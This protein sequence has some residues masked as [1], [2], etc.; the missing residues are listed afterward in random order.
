MRVKLSNGIRLIIMTVAIV[1]LCLSVWIGG[2]LIVIADDAPLASSLTRVLIIAAVSVIFLGWL[3][4]LFW[5]R[6]RAEKALEAALKPVGPTGDEQELSERMAEAIATL[7]K[8]SPSRNFLYELPWYVIIGPPGTGKTTA[9]M[10]SGLK[11]PLAAEG[12]KAA[13]G[14]AGG[15]RYC[16]WWFA[17]DA[18]LVDTAGRYTTQDSDAEADHKSWLSFLSLLKENRPKQPINGV[19]IAF[20]LEDMM[21]MK[22][23]E[24]S[25]HAAAIRKRLLELHETLRVDFPVYALFTK[26]DLVAGFNEFFGAFPEDRRRQVWGAT[27]QTEDR[28]KNC[29]G[30]V[31]KEFDALVKRLT[32]ETADRLQAE[33]DPM[34][35]IAIFGFAAQMAGLRDQ[36]AQFLA[37][38]FEPTR[39]HAN[40]HLRGFYFS[41]G[42]QMGTPI[43]QTLGLMERSLGRET[44]S[45]MSGKGKSYFL[46]D[47]LAKV[48]FREAGWV[49]R[50]MNAVRRLAAVRYGSIAALVVLTLGISSAWVWSYMNNRRLIASTNS[51]IMEYRT[52]GKPAIE[53]VVVTDSDFHNIVDLLHKLRNM[54]AG[55]AHRN[56]PTPLSERFGLSQRARLTS[57]GEEAYRAALERTFRSRLILRLERQIEANI[58]DPMVLYEA[59]KVYLM[60][61]G[62]APKEDNDLILAWMREDWAENLYPGAANKAG[63]EELEQHLRAMLDLEGA[64]NPSVELNGALVASAQQTLARMN[65]ADRAYTLIKSASTSAPL[66]PW[67]FADHGGQDSKVVFETVDGTPLEGVQVS[68]LFTYLGFQDFFLEQLSVV[69]D[70]LLAEQWVLGEYG[71]QAA[72]EEQ[73]SQLGP[74]LLE[75]YQRDF[76]QNWEAMLSQVRLKRLSA[77]KPQ[78]LA[79]A[80][81][82]APTSP[83]RA[84]FSSIRDETMLTEERG[85]D[86]QKDSNSKAGGVVAEVTQEATKRIQNRASGWSR[87]GIDA[88]LKKSQSRLGAG[89][90]PTVPGANIEAYFRSYQQL[91]DGEPGKRPIDA[92]I[93]NLYEIYQT[94]YVAANDASQTERATANLPVQI[95]NLRGNAS[96]LPPPL[97]KMMENAVADFEGDAADSSLSQLNQELSSGVTRACQDVTANRF[98]FASD[99]ERDVPLADFSK[100]FSPNGIIDHFFNEKLAKLVDMSGGTWDWKQDSRLGRELSKAT[101]REFQRASQ[102]KDAFFSSGAPMAGTQMTVRANT[103]SADADFALLEV[104]GN[105]VQAQ[106]V[107]NAPVPLT[108]PDNSPGSASITIHPDI[109]GRVSTMAARGPWAFMRLLAKGAVS[110][111]GD[112]VSVRFLVGGREVSFKIS[113]NSLANPLTLPALHEFKCPTGF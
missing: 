66:E 1:C 35:R 70:K 59:L 61:G 38:I 29:V 13:V 31:P 10:N 79:L 94:L 76:I 82:S 60:L 101:L 105:V 37:M 58:N 34:A 41:S 63:R 112:G 109:P 108:W 17:E 46:H 71:K 85:G 21:L 2:P 55:Y 50:D 26:A 6:R 45:Y 93:Q 33:P 87:I 15:T 27:F 12:S 104:N 107:G 69:A 97:A 90:A 7:R 81:A 30:E 89:S 16:D 56:D 8:A 74:G 99:S 25:A 73:F 91:V 32:E 65:L 43:D 5:R 3:G 54:E 48:I 84:I 92:L 67:N 11:F 72:V 110:Q 78:Y 103:M 9:L 106:Q 36:V 96:R 102:I 47:L 42:T 111:G 100:L 68:G 98:P 28:K 20:S 75:R 23:E 14:G 80:A 51:T 86:K 95:A 18:V 113:V 77:D 40:A 88:A 22:P 44:S 53:D 57:A 4:F 39:Y 83:I 64:H 62:K 24:V 49:S 52:I 19:I